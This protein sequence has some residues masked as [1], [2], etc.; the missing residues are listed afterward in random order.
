MCVSNTI[1]YNTHTLQG[2]DDADDVDD[3]D[4]V[5]EGG[6]C[7]EARTVA[8]TRMGNSFRHNSPMHP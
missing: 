2:T 5:E 1:Y 8:K 4:E 3:D 7:G 6:E